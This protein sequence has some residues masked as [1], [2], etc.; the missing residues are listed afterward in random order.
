MQSP[1]W[2]QRRSAVFALLYFIG[3]A[4]GWLA[5]GAHRY[6]PAYGG[7]RGLLI[8]AVL[9]TIACLAIRAWG[10]SFLTAATVWNAN[11]KTDKLIIAG[12]FRYTRHPLYLGNAFLAVGFGLL[13]PLPG[14][15]FIVVANALFIAALIRHEEALMLRH[16]GDAFR[17]Y[18]AS[19]PPFFPRVIPA[20]PDGLLNPSL[21]QGVLSEI[22]T[23]AIAAGLFAWIL[24]PHYGVY[25]FVVFYAAGV[26]AQQKI[27]QRSP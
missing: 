16:Y 27:D 19:V 3:F 1:W 4:G 12:P 25:L 11:A 10:S 9:F 22:F 21:A 5:M 18:C 7:N 15:I 13:A 8:L 2:Y 24:V 26:I 17:N 23:A 14:A 6:V 20:A